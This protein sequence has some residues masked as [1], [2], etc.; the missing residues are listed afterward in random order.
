[1]SRTDVHRP[2]HVQQADPYERHRW[3]RFQSDSTAAPTLVP[4]YRTCNCTVPGC[5]GN[6]W[7]REE[8]RR[9][10][11]GWRRLVQKGWL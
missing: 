9:D 6:V 7:R 2:H 3:Y 10:R 11:H 1:M 4:T 8:R 5:S